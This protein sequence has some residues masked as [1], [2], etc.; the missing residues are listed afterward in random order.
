MTLCH[1][2]IIGGYFLK[3]LHDTFIIDHEKVTTDHEAI[4]EIKPMVKDHE[5]KL[6]RLIAQHKMNHQ[7]G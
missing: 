4:K 3:K 7:G 1:R 5:K 6:T 2:C